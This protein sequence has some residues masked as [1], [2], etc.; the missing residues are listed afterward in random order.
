MRQMLR[1]YA[2]IRRFLTRFCLLFSTLSYFIALLIQFGIICVE[3]LAWLTNQ[4]ARLTNIGLSHVEFT[5]K[6]QRKLR[7]SLLNKKQKQK[8]LSKTIRVTINLIEL[9]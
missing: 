8:C 4:D 5:S 3:K 6:W 2:E 7:S 9:N 1:F